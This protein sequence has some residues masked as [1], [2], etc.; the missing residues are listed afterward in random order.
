M[1]DIKISVGQFAIKAPESA[2]DR[3]LKF[4]QGKIETNISKK[5]FDIYLSNSTMRYSRVKTLINRNLPLSI[6]GSNSIYVDTYVK[7]WKEPV[8]VNS[9]TDVLD[10]NNNIVF[11]GTG[12]S[13]KSFFVR[14]LFIDTVKNGNY[15]P[16]II[17]LRD[18]KT[19]YDIEKEDSGID[20]SEDGEYKSEYEIHLEKKRKARKL[21]NDNKEEIV[22]LV[23]NEFK[24]FGVNITE[25]FFKTSLKSGQYLFLFDGLD[26]VKSNY[27]NDVIED[28]ERLSKKYPGNIYFVFTRPFT[29][30]TNLLETFDFAELCKLSQKQAVTLVKK[31]GQFNDKKKVNQFIYELENGL[32]DNRYDFASNPLLLSIMFL[33]YLRNNSIPEDLVDFYESAYRALFNEHDANKPGAYIRNYK[34]EPLAAQQFKNL[35]SYFCFHSY[36]NQVYEFD[37]EELKRIVQKGIAKLELTSIFAVNRWKDFIDDLINNVCLLI[38]DGTRYVFVHRSFQ[39]YFAAYYIATHVSDENQEKLFILELYRLYISND[40]LLSILI[41]LAQKRLYHNLF[42]NNFD[43][44]FS[45]MENS[46]FPQKFFINQYLVSIVGKSVKY[47]KLGMLCHLFEEYIK[48]QSCYS[49]KAEAKAIATFVRREIYKRDSNKEDGF[50]DYN[51]RFIN[52]NDPRLIEELYQQIYADKTVNSIKR[53]IESVDAF[54]EKTIKEDGF[55]STL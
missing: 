42:M 20:S 24:S 5:E 38:L 2:V 45:D 1:G 22:R 28:I 19:A 12:G 39:T 25:E 16:I 54:D 53:W 3:L 4:I 35:L 10:T 32:Y 9:V 51:Y 29:I 40:F 44:Y 21:S 15:V 13:G 6:N 8:L 41:Q 48:P 11:E 33:V 27:Q 52:L 17:N 47:D 31:L 43:R 30:E 23:L 49:R 55:V 7:F 36:F 26:E 50:L 34:S 18:Y 14:H 46:P 37:E